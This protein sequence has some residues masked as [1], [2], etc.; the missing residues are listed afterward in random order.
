MALNEMPEWDPSGPERRSFRP[1]EIE[2]TGLNPTGEDFFKLITPYDYLVIN[3]F[4]VDTCR[5]DDLITFFNSVDR[6]AGEE[7]FLV[8]Q[9][10]GHGCRAYV[11]LDRASYEDFQRRRVILALGDEDDEPVQEA[12][13]HEGWPSSPYKD[14]WGR[15]LDNWADTAWSEC[16]N[17]AL[18][19]RKAIRD[20]AVLVEKDVEARAESLARVRER[21]KAHWGEEASNLFGYLSRGV[22]WY[23]DHPDATIIADNI[24]HLSKSGSPVAKMITP[25][26]IS[27]LNQQVG[28]EKVRTALD[29]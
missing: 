16:F 27:W 26:F 29:Q 3:K 10:G 14:P 13:E 19:I 8:K 17:A 7:V 6:E 4:G 18:T 28:A 15:D 24:H 11:R 5:S 22:T 1:R 23:N 21:M 12:E 20:L 9:V 2:V 25:E